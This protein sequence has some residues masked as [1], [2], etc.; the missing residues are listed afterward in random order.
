[1]ARR[2]AAFLRSEAAP[3]VLVGAAA[4]A[5][6][7]VDVASKPFHHDESEHAWFSWLLVTGQGYHYDPIYHG[8]VQYY[9]TGLSYLILGVGDFSARLAPAL[10][11]TGVTVLPYL[12]RRRIGYPAALAA[13]VLFCI[14]PTFLY[15]SRF[16]REDIYAACVTLAMVVV[17]FAFLARPRRWHPSLLLGLLAVSFA[18]KETTYITVAIC[19]PFFAL[20][21]VWEWRRRQTGRTPVL[22]A[23][24]SVGRDAWIWGGTSFLAV[25]TLLFTTFFTNP[26]GLQDGLIESIRYWLSQHPV[27]RGGHPPFYYLVVLPAYEWPV[28]VLGVIG[29]VAVLRRPTVV[30]L[31]LLWDFLVSLALYSAA[32]ERMPWLTVHPLLPLILLAGLGVQS[33]WQRRRAVTGR[34][35][36]ALALGGA[37]W[38]TQAAVALSFGHPADPK[39]MLVFTQTSAD[40]PGVRERIFELDRASLARRDRHVKIEV[41]GWGGTGWPWGWYLR[42]VPTA[43]PDMSEASFRPTGEVL[44]VADPSRERLLPFLG[45]YRGERFRLRVWW[46]VDHGAGSAGD[47]LRW[48][49][50]RNTWGP[51]GTLDEWIYVRKELAGSLTGRPSV[52]AALPSQGTPMRMNGR[53][54]SAWRTS[55]NDSARESSTP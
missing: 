34:V 47:W 37:A 55:A 43:Y 14:S 7:L 42:D 46:V 29:A 50:G 3:F 52:K 10:L 1:M 53:E 28:L 54:L 45:D 4:L 16:A 25:Y 19:A 20:V 17:A 2:V 49:T 6:R 36:L 41:D 8:P 35:A 5:L 22:T 40:V 48:L 33:L 30:G 23:I 32:G 12:L 39:E 27:N 38:S 13:S 24:R 31:F 18:T 21:A 15:F 51:L 11:G 26:H 44:L 9:L